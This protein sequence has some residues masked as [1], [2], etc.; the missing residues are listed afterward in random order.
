MRMM[1]LWNIA[2]L[3]RTKIKEFSYF[4]LLSEQSERKIQH[5]LSF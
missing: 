3:K 5:K 1:E 4:Y 2:E